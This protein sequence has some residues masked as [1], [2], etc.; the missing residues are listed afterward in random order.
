MHHHGPMTAEPR[1]HGTHPVSDGADVLRGGPAAAAHD[2][3]AGLH[4][5]PGVRGH[6]LRAGHVH[7]PPSDLA[8]H[9]GVGLG[10]ELALRQRRHP[11][12]ALQDALRPDGA[13]EADDIRA[14]AVEVADDVLRRRAEGRQSVRPDRHLRDDG[15]HGVDLARGRNRL[16]NLVEVAERLDDEAI[17]AAL[18]ERRH[19]LRERLARLFEAGGPVGLQPDSQRPDGPR[20]QATIPGDLPRDARRRGVELGHVRLEPV[21]GQLHAVRAERV[22]LQHLGAGVSVLRMH[23][24]DEI[25]RAGIELVVALVDEHAPGVQHRAHGPVEDDDGLGIEELVEEGLAGHRDAVRGTRDAPSPTA[26]R[27]PSPR[28]L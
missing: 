25:R 28:M 19:L 14:E 22:G 1:G 26:V 21:L 3:G 23:R 9:A 7:R 13:V 12:N 6:V 27:S 10:A 17:R 18:T 5:M 15:D 8:R 20:D 24:A 2:L 11:F 4:E 16:G